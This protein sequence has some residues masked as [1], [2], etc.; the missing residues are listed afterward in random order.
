MKEICWILAIVVVGSVV[1]WL[2]AP[3]AAMIE[4]QRK[5]DIREQQYDDGD[6]ERQRDDWHS[7]NDQ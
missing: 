7:V 1:V 6:L 5:E 4:E 2:A 3:Y